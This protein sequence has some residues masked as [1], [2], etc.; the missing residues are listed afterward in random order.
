MDLIA[1][2][3]EIIGWLLSHNEKRTAKIDGYVKRIQAVCVELVE[4]HDP[5][6]DKAALL[7]EQLKVLSEL[8]FERLPKSLSEQEGWNLF[9]GLSSARVYFWLRFLGSTKDSQLGALITERRE[10]SSASFDAFLKMLPSPDDRVDEVALSRIDDAALSRIKEQCL[11][12]IARI[13]EIRPFS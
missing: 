10:L 5:R 3:K 4:I 6:S 12:D 11:N 2:G 7:H 9:R 8:T 13:L 1:I